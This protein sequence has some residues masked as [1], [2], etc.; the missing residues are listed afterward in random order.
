MRGISRRK[1][2]WL[3][4]CVYK[5]KKPQFQRMFSDALCGGRDAALQEAMQFRD[6]VTGEAGHDINAKRKL[7]CEVVGFLREPTLGDY[8]FVKAYV[9]RLIRG[10]RFKA[11]R[12]DVIVEEVVQSSLLAYATISEDR[13]VDKF[14]YLQIQV[15]LALRSMI[16][17]FER[18]LVRVSTGLNG[19][20]GG[21]CRF[22]KF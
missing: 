11:I 21:R 9:E 16:L 5:D 15:G 19:V 14:R 7:R 18:R 17:K 12:S 2:D 8:H 3:V 10:R 22:V 1:T 6:K 20:E 4:R 13:L